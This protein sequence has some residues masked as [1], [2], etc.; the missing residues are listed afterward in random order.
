MAEEGLAAQILEIRVLDP[1]GAKLL[2]RQVESMLED[3]Q[4]CHQPC[5]Q[6]RH[7]GAV[8]ID[9]AEAFLQH[10]PVDR[11]RKA[12]QLVLQVDDLIKPGAEQ[13]LLA[14]LALLA[15]PGHR[16]FPDSPP[17]NAVNHASPRKGIMK[18]VLQGNRL[19]TPVILQS[20]SSQSA[21]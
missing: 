20:R 21:K 9:L 3:R 18:S 4:T 1:A 10:R 12:H 17:P 5:R 15:W 6:R 11:L 8:G 16:R 13:I 19:Q 7:A 2:V 14:R